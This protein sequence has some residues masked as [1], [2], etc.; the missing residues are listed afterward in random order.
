MP[1]C[2]FTDLVFCQTAQRAL[3][4]DLCVPEASPAPPPLVVWIPMGGMRVCR[5]DQAPWWL[6]EHGFAI[7][8]IECRVSAEALAPAA[9]HDA[10]AAIRWL[11]A[12]APEFGYRPE[13]IGVWGHSAGGLLASLLGTSGGVPDLEGPGGAAGV[14]SRVQAVCDHCGAPHD[15]AWF[16]GPEIKARFAT[17]AENLRLWLGQP[18]EHAPELARLV[19]STTYISAACP[20]LLL[21]HGDADSLVPVEE[22]IE[23]HDALR[24]VGVDAT[25][26]VLPGVDHGWDPVL[27]RDETVAFFRRTLAE[28]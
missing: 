15:L 20:P 25:L 19:S 9:V 22:T 12:H 16:A 10:K 2:R 3:R 14:S 11:R 28:P 4:L 13:A 27:T 23:F 17:V 24:A 1:P 26:R 6:T 7:A 21:I 8:S 5:K 18:V